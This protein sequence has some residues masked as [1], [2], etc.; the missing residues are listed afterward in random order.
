MLVALHTGPVEV[1]FCIFHDFVTVNRDNEWAK[2]KVI[3]RKEVD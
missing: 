2:K 3:E 1:V